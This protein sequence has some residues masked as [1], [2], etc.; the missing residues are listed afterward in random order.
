[1]E[2]YRPNCTEPGQAKKSVR[3]TRPVDLRPGW[4][5]V[6]QKVNDQVRSFLVFG[7]AARPSY[8]KKN[9]PGAYS[10]GEKPKAPKGPQGKGPKP[11]P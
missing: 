9:G 10:G 8:V 5:L 7:G 11:M 1:L 6:S 3:E 4:N 2:G